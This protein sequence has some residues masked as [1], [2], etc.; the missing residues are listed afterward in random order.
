MVHSILLS[1]RA[2]LRY[3][4]EI[5]ALNTDMNWFGVGGAG[6]IDGPQVATSERAESL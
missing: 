5:D 6:R 1:H 3:E 2:A 4:R